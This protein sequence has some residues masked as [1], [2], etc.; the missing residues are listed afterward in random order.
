[1]PTR[2]INLTLQMDGFLKTKIQNSQ[3]AHASEVI[4]AGLRAS[5]KDEQEDSAKLDA[6][7]EAIKA[8]NGT[9]F[10][11]ERDDRMP[12]RRRVFSLDKVQGFGSEEFSIKEWFPAVIRLKAPKNINRRGTPLQTS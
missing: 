2:N 1:M 11:L 7:R 10:G 8:E 5:E 12:K 3:Y 4:R 9:A 6:W